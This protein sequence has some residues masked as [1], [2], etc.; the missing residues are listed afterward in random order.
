[1]VVRMATGRPPK[2]N[3]RIMIKVADALQ[4]N[5]SVSEACL[6]AGISR[7]TYYYYLNNNPVFCE[8]MNIA[9]DNRNEVV[10]SF[11]TIF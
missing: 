4:H 10:F 1:M 11:L 7:P 5:A 9:L 8:K 2:M 6:Y 3:Y